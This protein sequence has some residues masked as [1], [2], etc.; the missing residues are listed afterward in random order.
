MS[1]KEYIVTLKK[2]VDATAFHNEMITIY[3][4]DTIPAR[5]ISVANERP[6]SRRNTHYYITE[7]EAI[8]IR[9]D[10]R[11]AGVEI[12]PDQNPDLIMVKHATQ[13]ADFTKTTDTEGN[14]VNWGLRRCNA[15]TN[16][17]TGATVSG[18]YNYNLDGTGVDVVIQDSGI[19][20]DHPDFFGAGGSSRVQQIDWYDASGVV[21]VMPAGHYTDYDGHGTHVAGIAVGT[22]YGWAKGARI[23]AQKLA[24]L[25]GSGD[26]N[27]G[28][29][30]FDS[31]D[32]IR[33]WHNNKPIDPSTGVKR[34]TIVNMSWGYR[35]SYSS[36]DSIVYR[37]V[38]Y[39]GAAVDTNSEREA[40]G[41]YPYE[42][43]A[44]IYAAPIRQPSVDA[45]IEDM[46]DDGIHICIAAGNLGFKIDREGGAD[47]NNRFT[48]GVTTVYYQQGSSPY[49]DRAFIVGNVDSDLHVGGLEQ[50][51][52]TSNAGPGVD[53][54]APGTNIFSTTSNEY[55]DP[56]GY[57][58]YDPNF[59]IANLSGTSMASPQVAG[60]L[61]LALQVNP[62]ASTN[63][64]KN[65]I[66]SRA[67][68]AQLYSSGSIEDYGNEASLLGSQNRFLFNTFNSADQM[69]V[70]SPAKGSTTTGT[71]NDIV[72]AYELSAFP[73]TTINENSSVTI[74][75]TTRNVDDGTQVPYTITG[76]TTDDINGA[77]LT[78]NFTINNKT[79]T[80][81]FTITPDA[82]TEG[83]ET[84]TLTLD[85]SA[86]SI[87][88]TINDTSVD[89][90][91]TLSAP[92]SVDEGDTLTV[93]LVTTDITDGT[94]VP[95]TVTGIDNLD[96]TTGSLTGN[97]TVTSNS[98]TQDF[99]LS[100]D[101][102]TEGTETFTL[103]LDNGEDSVNVD[104]LDISTTPVPTYSLTA[105]KPNVNEGDSVTFTLETT[106]VTDGTSVAYTIS[107]VSAADIVGGNLTGNFVI[108][109]DSTAGISTLTL[110]I[111]GDGI[112]EGSET[113]TV[114]LDNGEASVG[115]TINDTSQA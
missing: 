106:Y 41:L 85:Q 102:F 50:R 58:P 16:P 88:I 35:V 55:A 60:A 87:N 80:Q 36:V 68:T 109:S 75:V 100:L 52:P 70:E 27:T 89:P 81:T 84:L 64:S 73:G 63:Q 76:V 56:F 74:T 23:Y 94:L 7:T 49:A 115:V 93:T 67:K 32:T 105:N 54:Y 113:L 43:T 78:G 12:P 110:N 42:I 8:K 45:E 111:V 13:V 57:Y 112:T 103:S 92:I 104:I 14:F 96:L 66:L 46:I 28:M 9:Q 17:Y 101:Q 26:P 39:S 86:T 15:E 95:Y 31:F 83:P 34:P 65:Y 82:T 44:G 108:E 77:S 33:E 20:V 30:L 79:G 62:H 24:G 18:N 72:A 48:S 40:L 11:V 98:A 47:Y 97:F 91:Y 51:A 59:R 38:T 37:G 90:T 19:Q 3:G 71:V 99:L 4:S 21:G 2:G 114:A 29:P 61:A 53:I 22:N 25:E 69:V 107:G 6:Y 10:S 5:K 1:D